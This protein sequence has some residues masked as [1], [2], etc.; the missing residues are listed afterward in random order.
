MGGH[1]PDGFDAWIIS[2]IS[3]PIRQVHHDISRDAIVNKVVEHGAE[4]CASAAD[5][6]WQI[7]MWSNPLSSVDIRIA[8][9]DIDGASELLADGV[10][11]G[12]SL[13]HIILTHRTRSVDGECDLWGIIADERWDVYPMMYEAA[14]AGQEGVE[15]P[16]DA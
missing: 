6:H 3:V 4:I 7:G 16:V 12:M 9:H 13:Q 14:V 15:I 8:G 1:H 11:L 2:K 10:D 5:W